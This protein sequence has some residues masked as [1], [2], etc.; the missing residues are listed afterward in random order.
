MVTNGYKLLRLL[1][2]FVTAGARPKCLYIF[3]F[4]SKHFGHAILMGGRGGLK[5]LQFG[6]KLLQNK[7][8]LF[9]S[10][11]ATPLPLQGAGGR[12]FV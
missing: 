3:F 5:K 12:V 8:E 1:I 10:F 9:S 11:F 4:L 6:Y 7:K 2:G